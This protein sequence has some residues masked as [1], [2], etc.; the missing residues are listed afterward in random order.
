MKEKEVAEQVKE[1]L[2]SG[3]F[4]RFFGMTEGL[5]LEVK[6]KQAWGDITS[7]N[8]RY[9]FLK[10]VSS[11]ANAE[12]G[13]L[14][15]GLSTIP[16]DT[17]F[18]DKIESL[19]LFNEEKFNINCYLS[20]A[21]KNI[22]PKIRNIKCEWIKFNGDGGGIVSFFIPRQSHE[23]KLFLINKVFENKT[24]LKEIVV[25]IA[26]RDGSQNIPYNVVQLHKNIKYG[27]SSV[28]QRLIEIKT[29][30]SEI[31]S[32]QSLS[33]KTI[34]KITADEIP[35]QSG[36]TSYVSYIKTKLDGTSGFFYLE[37]IP[38]GEKKELDYF[39][40]SESD[41][42][43]AISNPP[44]LRSS[45][46]GLSTAYTERPS[47]GDGYWE[48]SNGNKKIV[49]VSRHGAVAT[50][51][52]IKDFLDCGVSNYQSREIRDFNGALINNYALVE[53]VYNYIRFLKEIAN[54]FKNHEGY[55]LS[56]GF[57]LISGTKLGLFRPYDLGHY[58][59]AVVGPL[60]QKISSIILAKQ[61][62]KLNPSL[63]AGKVI[64]EIYAICFKE[65]N[66]PLAYLD[67]NEKGQPF[68]Q[69]ERYL[70]NK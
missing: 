37:A 46:W 32:N 26:V 39:Y 2:A 14:L 10:D 23:D 1:I 36:L 9:E 63:L 22:Y 56:Y 38:L 3:D 31:L 30:V 25:G 24:N 42:Y 58:S 29:I 54:I 45:G 64:Q 57:D 12:G 43:K 59:N 68:V 53:Y 55:K 21:A 27:L 41:L 11:L 47:P 67:S 13:Y 18:A 65:V 16:S 15:V 48:S 8:A 7:P 44:D 66:L 35:A 20:I 50:A 70:K 49:I 6:N 33:R 62:F 4:A 17:G 28:S 34:A 52:S 5:Q 40:N 60:F 69:E 61:D 19:D 51:G